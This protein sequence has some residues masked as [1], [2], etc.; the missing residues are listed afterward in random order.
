MLPVLPVIS[1]TT[2]NNDYG[3]PVRLVYGIVL[4][5]VVLLTTFAPA[6]AISPTGNIGPGW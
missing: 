3:Q 4:T 5:F 6:S 1:L 2:L